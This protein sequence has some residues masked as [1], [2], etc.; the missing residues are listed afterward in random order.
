MK[1]FQSAFYCNITYGQISKT[2]TFVLTIASKVP[3]GGSIA[4]Q[5]PDKYSVFE[6]ISAVILAEAS[7]KESL[8]NPL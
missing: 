7:Y 8:G 2:G 5:L 3:G 1:H 4:I 6:F